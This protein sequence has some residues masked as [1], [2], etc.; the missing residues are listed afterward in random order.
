MA[1]ALRNTGTKDVPRTEG[2]L[3]TPQEKSLRA[4]VELGNPSER[5]TRTELLDRALNTALMLVEADAVVLTLSNR[6]GERIM[7]HAGN[8][9]P[10]ALQAPA[11][12]S[13]AIRRMLESGQPLVLADLIEEPRV[14]ETDGCPGVEAGPALFVPV[15]RRD[16]VPAAV[17]A[18]RRRGRARFAL[19]DS[20]ML[21]MLAAWL[22]G[23]LENLRLTTGNERSTIT[24]DLTEVY[25][26]RYLKTALRREVRRASRFRQ[27]LSVLMIDVDHLK[28]YNDAFGEL[29]GS[30]LLKEMALVLA[31]QVRSFDVLAKIGD[32]EFMVI[33]PQTHR[34][35]AV[36]VA[37][38]MRAAIERQAFS[39]SAAGAVTVS[40][41]AASFPHDA[42]EIRD[43]VAAAK[44]AVRNAKENG[45]NA[46]AALST[47]ANVTDLGPL[48]P[49]RRPA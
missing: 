4:L 18:Y 43:L 42:T 21:L 41:G 32:D 7:I 45:R 3:M 49:R 33:L 6:K 5:R 47:P 19:N 40:I 29:K 38:R 28:T 35:G 12:G 8:R 14:A 27:E 39:N 17:A 15:M 46:I 10:A 25:N 20:R 26:F 9:M 34:E 23:A 2:L 36:E 31:Q 37:E 24:D 44:R 48:I 16:P 30:L 11:E 1:Y 22:S 13:E